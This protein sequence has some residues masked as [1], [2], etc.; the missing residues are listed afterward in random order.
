MRQ[1][2][3]DDPHGIESWETTASSRC[4]VHIANSAQYKAITGMEP[5]TK[6]PSAK[7]YTDAG[8]PW[9]E[10]YADDLGVLGGSVKLAGL[11]SVA[12]LGIKKQEQPLP[13]NTP[14]NP[15][16]IVKIRPNAHLVRE[17]TF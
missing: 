14:V 8:L 16:H 3:C 10:Y 2:I 9:F 4:F 5:P 17:G 13:D 1:E 6:P 15:K 7:S 12:A 11:D